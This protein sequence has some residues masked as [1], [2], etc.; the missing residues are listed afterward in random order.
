MFDLQKIEKV[1]FAN[2]P[3]A[4]RDAAIGLVLFGFVG[5]AV[6]IFN[7]AG[8]FDAKYLWLAGIGIVPGSLCWLLSI[9]IR[10]RH[11]ATVPLT[12][13]LCALSLYLF[14][15]NP[16]NVIDGLSPKLPLMIVGW[17]VVIAEYVLVSSVIIFVFWLWKRDAFSQT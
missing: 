11:F 12:S 17:M 10:R 5:G 8:G 4:L 2:G 13:I 16:N 14:G 1:F 3:I 15:G 7:L 6:L 9:A